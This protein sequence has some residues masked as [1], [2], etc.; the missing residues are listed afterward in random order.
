MKGEIH[1]INQVIIPIEKRK[2]GKSLKA[3]NAVLQYGWCNLQRSRLGYD[4][5]DCG[6]RITN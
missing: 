1:C 6:V 4:V 5:R 3:S 2:L